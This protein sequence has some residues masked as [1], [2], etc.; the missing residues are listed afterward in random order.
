MKR[1]TK[2]G[3]IIPPEIELPPIKQRIYEALRKQPHSSEQLRQLIWGEWWRSISLRNI[4]VH[5][6]Q[7]NHLLKPHNLMVR[8]EW[9]GAYHLLERKP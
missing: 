7:L 8:G 4:H 5:I 2:C 9:R 6:H 3:H 1:C